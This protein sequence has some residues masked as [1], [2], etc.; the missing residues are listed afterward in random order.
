MIFSVLHLPLRVEL[1]FTCLFPPF[2]PSLSVISLYPFVRSP[3]PSICTP[4]PITCL[5]APFCIH[6]FVLPVYTSILTQIP[7]QWSVL[8]SLPYMR[9]LTTFRG[10]VRIGGLCR[11]KQKQHYKRRVTSADLNSSPF[12]SVPNFPGVRCPLLP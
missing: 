2:F 9:L 1:A 7:L 12:M 10:C 4:L 5:C 8:N 6:L 3:H 11:Q